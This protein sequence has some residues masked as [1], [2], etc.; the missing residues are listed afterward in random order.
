MQYVI[1]EVLTVQFWTKI[2][3]IF[4]PHAHNILNINKSN[5]EAYGKQHAAA[6]D[7]HHGEPGPAGPDHGALHH[8]R[9]GVPLPPRLDPGRPLLLS[10]VRREEDLARRSEGGVV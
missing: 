8:Q 4:E 3:L 2:I 10:H 6:G 9:A 7:P 1:T 5:R